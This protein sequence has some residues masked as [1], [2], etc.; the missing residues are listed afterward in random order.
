M[1]QGVSESGGQ[2]EL[3]PEM[4]LGSRARK[5]VRTSYIIVIK[6]GNVIWPENLTSESKPSARPPLP[7]ISREQVSEKMDNAHLE[8]E[9]SGAASSLTVILPSHCHHVHKTSSRNHLN[10]VSFFLNDT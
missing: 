7:A 4:Y 10:I 9:Q 1:H 3:R 6:L 5:T 8:I 2:L